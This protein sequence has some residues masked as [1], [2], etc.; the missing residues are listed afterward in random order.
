M[1]RIEWI[2]AFETGH[3][4][5][6]TEHRHLVDLVGEIQAAGAAEDRALLTAGVGRFLEAMGAHFRNEEAML[7][8]IGYPG[9]DAHQKAHRELLETGERA[10]EACA[11]EAPDEVALAVVDVLM[12]LI[13]DLV[14]AD[15]AFKS[16]LHEA[17]PG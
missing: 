10:R 16:H 8:R 11:A 6:D 12:V 17:D 5:I 2:K 3:E 13:G 9:L 15:H 4:A 14:E 1:A 7:A